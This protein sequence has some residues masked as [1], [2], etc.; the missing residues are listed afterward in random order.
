MKQTI[1]VTGATGFI[2]KHIVLKLLN[3]GY[4]VRGTVRDLSRGAEVVAAVRPHLT[5]A[6]DLDRRLTFVP[7]DLTRD[8]GWR[9]AMEGVDA[10]MHTASPFPLSQPKDEQDLIRPAVDG[11][12]RVVRTAAAAGVNRVILTS[13]IVAIMYSGSSARTATH[14]EADWTDPANPRASAYAKSKTLAERAAWDFVRDTAPQIKLTTINPALVLGPPLDQHFGSSVSIIE[15]VLRAKDPMVP[16][17]SFSVVDVR[18]VAEMHLRAV[19]RPDTAGQ[20]FLATSG[21]VWFVEIAAAIKAR[22]PA[23]KTVTR[24]A[25]DFLIRLLGLFDP[26]VR[27]IIPDLGRRDEFSNA[28]AVQEMGMTFIPPKEA[29]EAA[30]DYLID[31]KLV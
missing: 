5:D 29:I 17:L 15:R 26:T 19:Q 25:P 31:H 9:E 4:V 23:R 22:W 21:S 16:N 30:A 18:D 27:G 24:K 11:T 2:A 14:T 6:A 13:S 12:L 3:A 28:K 10:V 7:L 1:L 20:R 8:D